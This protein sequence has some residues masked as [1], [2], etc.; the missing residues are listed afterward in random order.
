MKKICQL[1]PEVRPSVTAVTAGATVVKIFTLS[2]VTSSAEIVKFTPVI[3]ERFISGRVRCTLEEF[4][5]T[6]RVIILN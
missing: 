1:G 3:S 2:S 6:V 4:I 5:A